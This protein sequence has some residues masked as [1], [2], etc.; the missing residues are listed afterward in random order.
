[1]TDEVFSDN[2]DEASKADTE[3]A[4]AV[5]ALPAEGE[6]VQAVAA[7]QATDGQAQSEQDD[8]EEQTAETTE[9]EDTEQDAGAKAVEEFSKS[10]RTLEGKWYVLH[11]YSGY[12]KRVKTN[13]ESRVASF[14]M[15]DKIFQVEVPMEEVEKHTEKGKKVI[16]RVRVPGYV[17]IRMLPDENARRIV[18]ETEGVTGF[19]GPTKDPAPLTRKEVVS[20]MAPMIASEA[21]KAAGDKP[22]AAKK[23]KLEVSYAPGDQV[24]VT[25]G[26]FTTMAA[27][28]SEVDPSTQKL[29]VLVSIFG[30]DTPVELGFN[31]VEK[32]A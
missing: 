6:A 24:T 27:V 20:M 26:P 15:E 8:P 28:V 13:V 22:A 17:L 7:D 19:V 29:T 32:L 16:T 30:R 2:L 23:R 11:T 5:E 9:D 18:R 25:D 10:L 1:M 4:A 3:A 31:Q 21:L 12:E 14:G